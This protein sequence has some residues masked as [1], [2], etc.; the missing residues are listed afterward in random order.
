MDD[1][2]ANE[3]GRRMEAIRFE[4]Y[5]H[6]WSESHNTFFAHYRKVDNGGSKFYYADEAD[7]EIA[8]LKAEVER[9]TNAIKTFSDKWQHYDNSTITG[10]DE[11]RQ[12][13]SGGR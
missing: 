12:A 6:I 2:E 13:L 1:T 8:R 4:F 7:A 5:N 3:I 9:L 11:L 10:L